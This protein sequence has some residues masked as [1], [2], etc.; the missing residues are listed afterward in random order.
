MSQAQA[1]KFSDQCY[2]KFS[3]KYSDRRRESAVNTLHNRSFR[4]VG[5]LKKFANIVTT[6]ADQRSKLK[7]MYVELHVQIENIWKRKIVLMNENAQIN[8]ISNVLT[9]RWRLQDVD[10]PFIKTK[11]FQK[12]VI[13][14][15]NIYKAK[16]RVRDD[17][18]R[19]HVFTQIFYAFS[20][21]SQNV[22]IKLFWMMK[23]NSYVDWTTLTWRF[24]I[25]FEKI[26]IQF[27]ENFFGSDDRVL[28]YV[29]ICITFN[30]EITL[31]MHKLLEFLKSYKN[32]FDFKNAKTLSEHENKDHII[33]LML[34]AKSLYESLYILSE[35]ELDVLRNY[36]LKNL[37]LSRI[38]EFRVVRAHWCSSFSKRT[39]IFDFVSIIKNWMF[40]SLKIDVRFR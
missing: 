22:I 2:W 17:V 4:W 15:I 16:I 38:R 5:K 14:F 39:I 9:K 33:N 35:T 6:I 1:G 25:N 23:T 24:E 40:W 18:A 28:V 13:T 32:Y 31:E 7:D 8:C 11:V 3:T 30:V 26:T 21:V 19:E 37:T 27:F 10:R 29:L 36:L 34:D 20:K 12:N